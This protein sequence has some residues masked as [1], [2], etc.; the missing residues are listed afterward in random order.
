[1]PDPSIADFRLPSSLD[2]R[3]CDVYFFE[4]WSGYAHPV[5]PEKPL[6]YRAALKR[7]GFC[8]AY[9]LPSPEGPLMVRFKCVRYARTRV[10]VDVPGLQTANVERY[11]EVTRGKDDVRAG[12]EMTASLAIEAEE[13]L[14]ISPSQQGKSTYEA[15]LAKIEHWYVYDY[16]YDRGELVRAVIDNGSRKNTLEMERGKPKK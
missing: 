4:S 14:S 10:S 12:R 1:M 2:G 13:F 7:S 5:K 16:Q 6:P 8:R 3:P 11:F 9:L 15:E